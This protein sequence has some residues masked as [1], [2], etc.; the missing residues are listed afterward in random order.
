MLMAIRTPFFNKYYNSLKTL[1]SKTSCISLAPT[2]SPMLASHSRALMSPT[3]D[4]G[5]GQLV[6]DEL[7]KWKRFVIIQQIEQALSIF[8]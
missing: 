3:I 4:A 5:H 7:L 6:P 1:S 8:L 2:S